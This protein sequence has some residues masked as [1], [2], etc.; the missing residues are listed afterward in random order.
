MP[1]TEDCLVFLAYLQA[2]LKRHIQ[3]YTY[4]Y[5]TMQKNNAIQ[6]LSVYKYLLVQYNFLYKYFLAVLAPLPI[7]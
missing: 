3:I 2:Y 7:W 5:T 1:Y 4:L 6:K